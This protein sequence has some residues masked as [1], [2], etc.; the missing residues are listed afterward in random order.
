MQYYIKYCG[1][2][3]EELYIFPKQGYAKLVAPKAQGHNLNK[4][5]GCPQGDATY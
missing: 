4:V 3:Q 5:G 2:R 1:L